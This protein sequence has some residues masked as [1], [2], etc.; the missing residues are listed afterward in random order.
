MSTE[1]L[2]P[3]EHIR[4]QSKIGKILAKMIDEFKV[5]HKT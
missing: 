2:Q 3:T 4:L 5:Q 1:A